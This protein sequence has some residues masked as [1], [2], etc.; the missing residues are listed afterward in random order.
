MKSG[1]V[2]ME[3]NTTLVQNYP[4]HEAVPGGPGPFPAVVLVHDE[5]GLNL[6]ARGVANRL[7]AAGFYALAPAL[8]ALPAS[9]VELAP[10]IMHS[11]APIQFGYADE[12]E[13]QARASTLTDE[14]A[15]ELVGRA[16]RYA[17]SRSAA[18]SGPVGLLGFSMGARVAFRAACELADDVAACVGFYPDRLFSDRLGPGHPMPMS[19]AVALKAPLLLLYGSLD[20]Q[21]SASEREGVRKILSSL[22][23]DVALEQ[24]R[25]AGH[26]FFCSDRE[27][28][29]V[30]AARKAWEATLAFFRVRLGQG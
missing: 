20:E 30:G 2:D 13:A 8:Y 6:Q 23:K 22:G 12:A 24:Y 3:S 14:R 4:A 1:M 7:A 28:F 18:R 21:V 19:G 17:Q 10:Q 16:I 25:N 29:R 11:P 15:L 26:D 5:F 27:S 9:F